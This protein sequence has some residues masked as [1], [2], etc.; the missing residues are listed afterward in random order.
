[1][2][3]GKKEKFALFWL[4]CWMRLIVFSADV[5]KFIASRAIVFSAWAMQS[6]MNTVVK[7]QDQYKEEKRK[8]DNELQYVVDECDPEGNISPENMKYAIEVKRTNNAR[9]YKT[10]RDI[11]KD[12]AIQKKQEEN[13]KIVDAFN[14]SQEEKKAEAHNRIR[15]KDIK[16]AFKISKKR[17]PKDYGIEPNYGINGR[18]RDQLKEHVRKIRGISED[19]EVDLSEITNDEYSKLAD[20]GVILRTEDKK[21]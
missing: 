10:A 4:R 5:I 16:S 9:D 8:S 1:M 19:I 13:K 12:E 2:K 11:A 6:A 21:E 17:D 18:L 14:I 7:A 20:N 3:V 15:T